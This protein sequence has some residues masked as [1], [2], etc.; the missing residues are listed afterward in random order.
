MT[1]PDTKQDALE[2][3]EATRVKF[4]GMAADSLE[5]LPELDDVMVFTVTAVCTGRGRERMKD[6]ERRATARMDVQSLVPQGPPKKP[7]SAPAP[8]ALFR[9]PNGDNEDGDTDGETFDGHVDDDK[10]SD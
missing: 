7:D 2:G 3:M 8:P 9:V 5:Q 4:V 6:G 1:A 10:D